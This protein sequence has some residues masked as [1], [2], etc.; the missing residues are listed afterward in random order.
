MIVYN[1]TCI[2]LRNNIAYV[3]PV[4]AINELTKFYC[5]WVKGMAANKIRKKFITTLD[6]YLYTSIVIIAVALFSVIYLLNLNIHG[7]VCVLD[8]YITYL[9]ELTEPNPP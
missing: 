9:T 2:I 3:L 7:I 5:N 6:K 4:F 1:Y 8:Q